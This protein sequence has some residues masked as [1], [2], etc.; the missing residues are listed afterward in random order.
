M[1]PA[2]FFS[3]RT[4]KDFEKKSLSVFYLQAEKNE[5]YKSYLSQIGIDPEKIQ[6]VSQIPFLPIEI[7]KTQEVITGTRHSA[8]GIQHVFHSSGTTG[9][10]RSRHYVLD[11]S[12][13]EKSFQKCFELFFGKANQYAIL[14]ILPSYYE[15]KHSSLMY[16]VMD[17]IRNSRNKYSSFY[18]SKDENLQQ[19]IE[20]LLKQKQKTILFGVSSAL[21]D[22]PYNKTKSSKDLLVIETG[23]MK[24][25]REELTREE[26]H[27]TLCDKFGVKNIYSEYGMTELLSQAYSTGK[28]IFKCPPWMKVLAR[29][30]NDPF[31]LLPYEK[32]GAL[33]IID[34]ANINSCSFIA[35]QD[36]GKI[37]KDRSFEMLG[38]MDN[39]D[40]RG[41]NLLAL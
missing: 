28:G 41:C 23:G 33:N 40:L 16:M 30:A 11:I 4:K 13:Y 12:I 25:R 15:N 21:L 1:N 9:T 34:L 26:L 3:V 10:E 38:R 14:A 2:E 35:T 6:S 31:Q 20:T 8:S 32:T 39:S 17:L 24:G 19:I 36:V 29:D 7:F 37:Y 18:N 27:A 5:V 22:L